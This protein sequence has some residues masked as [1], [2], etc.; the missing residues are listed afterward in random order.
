M[1]LP[2]IGRRRNRMNKERESETEIGVCEEMGKR[3]GREGGN[4]E[5]KG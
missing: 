1:Q 5:E 4:V 3:N 2:A